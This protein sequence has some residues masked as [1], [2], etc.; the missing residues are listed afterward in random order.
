MITPHGIQLFGVLALTMTGSL[1]RQ[2]SHATSL[3]TISHM[4]CA[5]FAMLVLVGELGLT[6]LAACACSVPR[7]LEVS[8]GHVPNAGAL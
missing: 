8:G 7:W 6:H 5:T 3:L 4:T 2:R 1:P